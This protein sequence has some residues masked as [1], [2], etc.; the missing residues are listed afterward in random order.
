MNYYLLDYIL[1][2]TSFQEYFTRYHKM[3]ENS[4]TCLKGV[5]HNLTNTFLPSFK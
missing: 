4:G 2:F 1:Y 5:K 3:K